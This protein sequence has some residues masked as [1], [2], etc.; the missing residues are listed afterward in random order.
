MAL[1]AGL[2][3]DRRDV[4]GESR[5]RRVGGQAGAATSAATVSAAKDVK[6]RIMSPPRAVTSVADEVWRLPLQPGVPVPPV[7]PVPPYQPT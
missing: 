3:E 2:V 6:V 5:R 1:D 4:F 7:L